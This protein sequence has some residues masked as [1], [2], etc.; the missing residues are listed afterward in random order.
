[1]EERAILAC[2]NDKRRPQAPFG[3]ALRAPLL[4][5]R[6]RGLCGSLGLFFRHVLDGLV[7]MVLDLALVFHDLAVKF[8]Y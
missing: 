8:V 5:E 7:I 2:A 1:M 3:A 6:L 4:Q